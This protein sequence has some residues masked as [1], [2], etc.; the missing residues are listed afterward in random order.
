MYKKSGKKA[1]YSICNVDAEY[2]MLFVEVMD[3][4]IFR[5]VTIDSKE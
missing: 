4:D 2:S 3:Y 5:E 1:I